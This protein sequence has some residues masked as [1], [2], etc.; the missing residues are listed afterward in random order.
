M[1]FSLPVAIGAS[2]ARPDKIVFSINGDGGFHMSLQSLM[3]ISQYDLPIKVIVLNNQSL[4]MITQFQDL[5]F[6]G[7]KSGTTVEGGYMIPDIESLALAYGLSYYRLIE[8]DLQNK[9]LLGSIFSCRNCIVE[10]VIEGK[11]TVSPKLEYNKPI[12]MPLPL[13]PEEELKDS[14]VVEIS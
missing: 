13:L 8:E 4:G 2:F 3:L 7:R 5:Y 12:E 1:G 11:T 6:A 14:M 10:Y 9:E